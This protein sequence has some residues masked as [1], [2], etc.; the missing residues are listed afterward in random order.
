MLSNEVGA[1]QPAATTSRSASM[2]RLL[3]SP[4]STTTA[5]TAREEPVVELIDHMLSPAQLR[6]DKPLVCLFC[7][8]LKTPSA[9]NAR[10]T[11]A[12]LLASGKAAPPA[13]RFRS[14]TGFRQ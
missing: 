14:R 10:D 1:V 4:S 11:R 7:S 6:K 2:R 13:Y 9:V 5:S 3:A 8:H 12:R